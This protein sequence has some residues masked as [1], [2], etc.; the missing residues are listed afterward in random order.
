MVFELKIV[1]SCWSR[2]KQKGFLRTKMTELLSK[3]TGSSLISLKTP[4]FILTCSS[5]IMFCKYI[6]NKQNYSR[7]SPH[8]MCFNLGVAVCIFYQQGMAAMHF[9]EHRV[10][11]ILTGQICRYL[12]FFPGEGRQRSPGFKVPKMTWQINKDSGKAGYLHRPTTTFKYGENSFC[13]FKLNLFPSNFSF[14]LQLSPV[15]LLT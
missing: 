3:I 4:A 2:E 14:S 10:P 8:S 11:I 5:L 9:R 12:P 13:V 6:R 15:H 7:A 1:K